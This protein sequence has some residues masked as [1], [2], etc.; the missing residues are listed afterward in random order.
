LGAEGRAD[1]LFAAL[2]GRAWR[3]RTAGTG[4][5]GERLYSWARIRINGPA[6]TGEHWLLARRSVKDP[7]DLAY[8]I[9]YTPENVTLR[10]S[11]F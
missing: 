2:D 5:K 9:R 7:T 3:T 10:P 8:F 4:T 1:Q 6:E 11:S